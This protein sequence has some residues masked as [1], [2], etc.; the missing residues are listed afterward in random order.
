MIGSYHG[1]KVYKIVEAVSIFSWVI[2]L[3]L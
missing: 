3:L 1:M 2:L